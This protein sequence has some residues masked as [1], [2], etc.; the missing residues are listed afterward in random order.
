MYDNDLI[1][2]VK[3]YKVPKKVPKLDDKHLLFPIQNINL[4]KEDINN[5][6]NF[7][8]FT[9]NNI[10][11]K[12]NTKPKENNNKKHKKRKVSSV[13]KSNLKNSNNV[14]HN[15][16]NRHSS[17]KE[18]NYFQKEKEYLMNKNN[19]E[20]EVNYFQKEKEY[21][22]NKNNLEKED[23]KNYYN[24]KIN[25]ECE[26]PKKEKI[27]KKESK[28]KKPKI[29]YDKKLQEVQNEN[30]LLK[31]TV[32]KKE[33]II[34]KYQKRFESQ[35][36]MLKDLEFIYN[37]M[38]KDKTPNFNINDY[39]LNDLMNNDKNNVK[40]NEFFDK[41]NNDEFNDDILNNE[42]LQEEMAIKAVDQQ[43]LDELC[44]NPDVMSYEQLLQLEENVGNVSKGLTSQQIDFL[45][46]TK[47]KKQLYSENYQCIIC[48]EE[49]EEKEKV[50][51]LP[52]GHIFHINC[53]KQWLL[54][55]KSCPFCKSEIK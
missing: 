30:L 13:A 20:K 24:N 55:Q 29:D 1:N 54:K 39:D 5:N 51:L 41:Y 36:D 16:K 27:D 38:K 4:P 8:G 19:L 9:F 18:V 45:P 35:E 28:V 25:I 47:Y 33:E 49:F 53:I 2:Y 22:M 12:D 21:L 23:S 7:F 32:R 42:D 26:M 40:D 43:I 3:K 15:H 52:C 17:T 50:K 11:F 6:D 34:K 46:V 37:E 48:M 44:P 31:R 14:T 10:Q